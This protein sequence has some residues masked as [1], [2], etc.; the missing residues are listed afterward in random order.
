METLSL[1]Q[2]PLAILLHLTAAMYALAIGA[3][4]VFRRKGTLVHRWVGRVWAA[5]MLYVA[6]GS[7]W[8]RTDG[9]LSPIHLLSVITIVAI[10]YA[11]WAIRQGNVRAHRT[12]MV[13][14][15]A[16]LVI[17]GAFTLLPDRLLGQLVFG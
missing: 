16:G 17:A 1:D 5:L 15:Y 7:F 12:S 3:F 6:I 14:S 2:A 4:V 8:I 11:V 9:H 13:F 10:G